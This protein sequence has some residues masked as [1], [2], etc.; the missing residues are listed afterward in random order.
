MEHTTKVITIELETI[1]FKILLVSTSLP[2]LMLIYKLHNK[3]CTWLTNVRG[4]IFAFTT[5]VLTCV[6]MKLMVI[7]KEWVKIRTNGY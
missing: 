5:H 2:F 1:L 6:L 7:F 4:F 3:R